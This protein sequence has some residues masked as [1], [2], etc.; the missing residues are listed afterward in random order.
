MTG[1]RLPAAHACGKSDR[2]RF[3]T[4]HRRRDALREHLNGC[5]VDGDFI[6]PRPMHLGGCFAGLGYGR[7]TIVVAERAA[8][9]CESPP[10]V[11]GLFDDQ[12]LAAME[13]VNAFRWDPPRP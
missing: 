1:V 9:T 10:I 5:G 2:N 11:S 12:V 7:I 13:P 6:C 8:E 4:A 3:T